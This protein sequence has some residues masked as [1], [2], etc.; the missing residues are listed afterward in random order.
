MCTNLEELTKAV[1]ALDYADFRRVT[2]SAKAIME[3]GLKVNFKAGDRVSFTTR[4]GDKMLGTVIKPMVRNIDVRADDGMSW[5][6][7]PALLRK[8]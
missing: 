3:I 7:N 5:R 4:G 1:G 8:E 6:I 2:K